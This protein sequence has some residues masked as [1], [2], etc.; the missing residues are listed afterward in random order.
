MSQEYADGLRIMLVGISGVF[1][2]LIILML[3]LKG[4]GRVFGKKPKTDKKN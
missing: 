3:L 1:A 2:N 4:L